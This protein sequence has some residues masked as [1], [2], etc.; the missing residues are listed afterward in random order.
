MKIINEDYHI[1]AYRS[2]DEEAIVE[3]FAQ[4]FGKRLT[5]DQW[6]WKYTAGGPI[7]P[8]RLAFDASGCLVGHA[9]AIPL[10]G[11]RQGRP[12]PFFQIC[13]V[14][15]H[16]SAR[17]WLGD[18]NLFTRLARELLIGLAERWPNALAYGFPGRRPYRL[19]EYARVYEEVEQACAVHRPV[20]HGWLPFPGVRA[21]D[22]DDRRL[23]SL[24]PRLAPGFAMA[25]VRDHDYLRWRYAVNPFHSYQLLGLYFG[26]LLLGWVVVRRDGGRL[27]VVDLLLHRRWLRL[28]L[29]A[30]A[31]TAAMEGASEV[32]IWLPRGWR[33]AAGKLAEPTEVVLANMIWA[34][35]ITTTEVRGDLYYTMGD[36]DIF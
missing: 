31:R 20:H 19:G 36:L 22:W 10:R 5:T 17:G 9:G 2:G 33:E 28:A 34:L 15:V 25:L 8:V 16:P 11:W 21:L 29:A 6:R 18:Q 1:R 30:L 3:L 27:L 26:R 35:R 14:M 4:V 32:V 23:D 12:L 13:D 24:W 7:P